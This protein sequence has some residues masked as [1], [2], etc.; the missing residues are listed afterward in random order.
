MGMVGGFLKQMNDTMQQNRRLLKKSDKSKSRQVR[1]A[2]NE[3]IKKQASRF[4]QVDVDALKERVRKKL[5]RNI[6]Q[7]KII[8]VI[9]LTLV[10]TFLVA[11]MWAIISF[12]FT[13]KKKSPFTDSQS[14]FKTEI[15]PHDQ[16]GYS[17]KVDYY[18]H[19]PK[20][21][22]SLIKNGLKHQ[23]SE[24]YYPSGEQFRS[25][26]YYYDTLVRE[27]SFFKDGDTI[28][29]FQLWIITK[30]IK[31]NS[32]DQTKTELLNFISLTEKLFRKPIGSFPIFIRT[33]PCIMIFIQI[34]QDIPNQSTPIDLTSPTDV[35]LYI[36]LPILM[37][38][39]YLFWRKR[40]NK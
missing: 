40:K 23:N 29:T 34:P 16:A 19:G 13:V 35:M 30:S 2:Y 24:S 17:L 25:A 18:H 6:I 14:L 8:K 39:L 15:H 38:I 21:A 20:A 11:I 10:T 31:S 12:D 1:E 5:Q 4:N 32:H 28:K 26:L 22:E 9:A 36:I 33:N 7:E 37:I 27:V 3:E